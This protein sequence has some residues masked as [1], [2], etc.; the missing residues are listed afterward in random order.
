MVSFRQEIEKKKESHA[1]CMGI[2]AFQSG[3]YKEKMVKSPFP[4][5]SAADKEWL[6]GFYDAWY[7]RIVTGGKYESGN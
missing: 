5:D 3:G 4:E 7:M 2:D 6:D 1:Y